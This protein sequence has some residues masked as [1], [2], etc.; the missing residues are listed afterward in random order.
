[1]E[2]FE[3]WIYR[4]LFNSVDWIKL[5]EYFGHGKEDGAHYR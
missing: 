2:A 3:M 1:M 4:R 5:L